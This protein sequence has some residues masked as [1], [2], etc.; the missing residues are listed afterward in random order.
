MT[1]D[2]LSSR[3]ESGRLSEMTTPI[4]DG[5]F[6]RNPD[7]ATARTRMAVARRSS[8]LST[9]LRI[10]IGG[11]GVVT[12][13]VA[14]FFGGFLWFAFEIAWSR[15][16]ADP[17]ADGIVALTGG[18]D[19]VQGA[20][21][22]LEGRHGRRLLISGVHP[23][24]TLSDIA[25]ATE[26]DRSVFDCCVDLGRKAETTVGNAQEAAEWARSNGFSSLIVVTSA[27]HMP[28]SLVELDR[29]LPGVRMIAYPVT[30]SDLHL[31]TWFLY[32]KTTK[33]L[34][35]EYLKYMVA[36][37]GPIAGRVVPT[38]VAQRGDA[39]ASE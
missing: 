25:R 6:T 35:Q 10:A 13:V 29:A 4:G 39:Q 36:R 15:V 5:G 20:V 38:V 19:R 26:G 2:L 7:A 11:I 18:R 21:D 32:A 37:F 3:R 8:P 28:R 14:L 23:L 31:G 22:L 27:Y 17:N 30:R 16:P 12:L 1:I 33:L 9:A 34:F 24:T